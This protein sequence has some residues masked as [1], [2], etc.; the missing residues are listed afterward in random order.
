MMWFWLGVV[1]MLCIALAF[2]VVPLLRRGLDSTPHREAVNVAIHRER[3]EELKAERDAGRVEPEQYDA[4]KR[5]LE[6][7]LLRDVGGSVSSAPAHRPRRHW[8]SA[9]AAVVLVPVLAGYGYSQLGAYGLID[10]IPVAQAESA[11]SV[12]QMIARL[13]KRLKEQPDDSEGWRFLGRSYL[14]LERFGE[15]AEAYQRAYD[16][17]GEHPELMTDLAEALSL[18]NGTSMAGR[19]KALIERTLELEPD[20]PKALWLAGVGAYQRGDW[21]QSIDHWT[22]LVGQLPPDS[23]DA[24]LVNR[25]IVDARRQLGVA[26]ADVIAIGARI[27]VRLEISRALKDRA[28]PQDDVFLY[29]SPEDDLGPPAAVA[30]LRVSDLPTTIVLNDDKAVIPTR[31]LSHYKRVVVGARVARSGAAS[32][33]TG[34]LSANAESVEVGQQGMVTLVIDH[35]V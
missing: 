31:K 24:G 9:L 4:A 35:E 25:V 16:L 1:A 14:V 27:T 7:E 15:A 3:V 33:R 2:V 28:R 11:P 18:V 17:E 13:K 21:Q 23:E 30:R 10:G 34:D 6:L 22:R 32:K 20:L 29:A 12:E 8:R 19:P 5:E 26:P